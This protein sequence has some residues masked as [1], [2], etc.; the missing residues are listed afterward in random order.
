MFALCVAYPL[1]T[2]APQTIFKEA[3][4]CE[5]EVEVE[6]AS[7]VKIAANV[8]RDSDV[9]HV[10]IEA[11][12]SGIE[13][14]CSCAQMGSKWCADV[15]IV[16]LRVRAQCGDEVAEEWTPEHGGMYAVVSET[17]HGDT[18]Q[19]T[20]TL[21]KVVGLLP[22]QVHWYE[23]HA[24]GRFTPMCLKDDSKSRKGCGRKNIPYVEQVE[25]DSILRHKVSLHKCGAAKDKICQ[26]D[27]RIVLRLW[28]VYWDNHC[29]SA[30]TK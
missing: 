23:P 28:Q 22:L 2:H 10:I 27:L 7:E 17:L 6:V 14:H 13:A 5:A 12:S 1:A 8:K 11:G 21:A 15:V 3:A 19:Y 4:K 18:M 9:Y 26:S 25:P 20:W 30:H 24:K 16:A 29:V